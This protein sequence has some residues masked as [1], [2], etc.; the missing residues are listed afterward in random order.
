[1]AARTFLGVQHFKLDAH[2]PRHGG[3]VAVAVHLGLG[4][5]QP[6]ATVAVVIPYGVVGIIA[7]LFVEVDR[8]RFQAD[9]RLVHPK[10]RDLCGRVP[11]G[12]RGQL[13]PLHQHNIAPA[14]LGQVIEG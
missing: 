4:V 10:I 6:Y 1:M 7:Q 2:A 8:V 3:K 13:V 9:H 11:C 12:A 14:L 5:G